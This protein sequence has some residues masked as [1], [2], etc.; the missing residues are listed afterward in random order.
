MQPQYP[1][2]Q[3]LIVS[4]YLSPVFGFGC[5]LDRLS[6]S[7]RL[8][9][10]QPPNQ[11]TQ[12][13]PSEQTPS[14]DAIFSTRNP[15][16]AVAGLSSGLK[17]IGKGL[18]GG[19]ASLVALPI[20][21]AR[22]EGAVGFAK[23]LGLGLVSAVGL[24][25]LGAGTGIIQVGRG[26]INTPFALQAKSD[27]KVW[28]QEKRVWYYYN[29]SEEA[30][31]ELKKPLAHAPSATIK[32]T[33]LYDI[34]GID[35]SA[36]PAEV[37]KAYRVKAIRLHPDK[38]PNNPNASSNF[39]QLGEAYQV[40]SNPALRASYDLHG[41][42]AVDS[43]K[44]MDSSQL[45]QVI[46]GSERFEDLVGELQLMGLQGAMKPNSSTEAA[47]EGLMDAE[48]KLKTKQKRREVQCA[49][50]LVRMLNDYLQDQSENHVAFK[51]SIEG[52]AKELTETAFGGTLIAVVV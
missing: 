40:I 47:F 39:Q 18:F 20:Q 33:K 44:L 42:D 41:L 2:T 9:M 3:I 21:G 23:G 36:T 43:D 48:A 25:V 4:Y 49:V 32:D 16:D 28:D 29:L 45:Y 51:V 19:V 12:P 1:N 34:L 17:S 6:H 10:S 50:N 26:I 46:F 52:Q 31:Q 24:T 5:S 30:E 13:E 22:E 14:F 15:K 35:P 11:V 38:N 37:K 27:E 8:T 7:T